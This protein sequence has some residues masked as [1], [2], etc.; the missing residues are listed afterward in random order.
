MSKADIRIQELLDSENVAVNFQWF[1]KHS[2]S[3][4]KQEGVLARF[5]TS[6]HLLTFEECEE[7]DLLVLSIDGE[8][9]AGIDRI[10]R[11]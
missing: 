6:K 2:A 9:I 5:K 1:I 8:E 10:N 7:R 11:K 3:T 4:K